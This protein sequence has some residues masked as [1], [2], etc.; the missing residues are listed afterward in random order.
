MGLLLGGQGKG[1]LDAGIGSID[2]LIQ[3][4][5]N[6]AIVIEA[7]PFTEGVLGNFEAAI[8]ITS[9][10]RGE[11]EADGESERFRS[12]AMQQGVFVAGLG[13]GQPELLPDLLLV[14]STGG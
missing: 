4:C 14:G 8:D 11:V 9:E 10:R 2:I 13:Q 6:N 5:F 7:D 3:M 12:K 1:N